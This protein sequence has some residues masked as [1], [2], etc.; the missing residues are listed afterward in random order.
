MVLFP[1][2]DANFAQRCSLAQHE[3]SNV[4][5][6]ISWIATM[7]IYQPFAQEVGSLQLLADPIHSMSSKQRPV[8]STAVISGGKDNDDK[9]AS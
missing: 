5:N 1:D 4:K 7:L 3:D 6:S 2:V 9:E 8:S